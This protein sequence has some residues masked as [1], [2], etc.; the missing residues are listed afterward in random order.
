MTAERLCTICVRSGSK[1]VPDKNIAQFAGKPLLQHSV[2]QAIRSNSFS[3]VAVSSDA[4]D[5][6]EIGRAA[7]ADILVERPAALASD[8][9]AKVPVIRHCVEA[10]EAQT[11][12]TYGIVVDLQVTSPL[13][14]PADINNA[15]KMLESDP[16]AQ[17]VIAGTAAKSSP[18]FTLIERQPDGYVTLSKPLP[19]AVARRQ[20]APACYDIN[21][22]VYV[23]RRE[24]LFARDGVLLDRTALYVMP[25]HRSLDIDTPLDF[26]LAARVAERFDWDS[27]EL[28]LPARG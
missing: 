26:F 10:A 13:R 1:A 15:V 20:D 9:A 24:T 28:N 4:P 22:S 27:G 5:Y 17:N 2:E 21:G 14:I 6:L 3:A 18:Y 25:E 16:E 7:G 12:V 19:D 8:T 23:W 11:G